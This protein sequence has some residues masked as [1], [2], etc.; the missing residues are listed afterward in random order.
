[1]F[2]NFS[3]IC[4]Q[5]IAYIE[6]IPKYLWCIHLE[7][8]LKFADSHTRSYKKEMRT[9]HSKPFDIYAKSTYVQLKV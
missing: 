5:C 3:S 6:V 8:C 4:A 7:D 9:T 1:M 2:K